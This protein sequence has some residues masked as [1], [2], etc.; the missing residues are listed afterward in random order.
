MQCNDKID[1]YG[2][3]KVMMVMVVAGARVHDGH[4]QDDHQPDT[5]RAS[6]CNVMIIMMM[7]MMMMVMVK[8]MVMMVVAGPRVHDGNT[9]DDHQPNRATVMVLKSNG[10]GGRG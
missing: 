5:E 7:M 10:C 3:R 8:V 6:Q 1:N 2:D 9:Q 4:T